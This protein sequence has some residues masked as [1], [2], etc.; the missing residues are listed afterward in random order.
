MKIRF[1]T[2]LTVVLVVSLFRLLP[3]PPNFTPVMAVALFAGAHFASRWIAYFVPL[4]AMLVADVVLGF[5]GSMPFVY[6][7]VAMTVFLGTGIATSKGSLVQVFATAVAGSGLFFVVTNF[8]AWLFLREF[9]PA[10]LAGLGTAYLAAIPFYY[11]SLLGDLFY[12]GIL[13]GGFALAR[14][15]WPVL[16]DESPAAV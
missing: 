13:F 4:A 8:G 5:H 7:C 15:V 10:T 9:Y 1:Y 12:T 16:R 14:Q 3:H 11:N 6:L 2:L